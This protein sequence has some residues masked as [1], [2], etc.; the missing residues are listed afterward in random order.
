MRYMR[1]A[2]EGLWR[3]TYLIRSRRPCRRGDDATNLRHRHRRTW[4]CMAHMERTWRFH[5]SGWCDAR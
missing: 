2:H 4:V 1:T 3:K 5:C